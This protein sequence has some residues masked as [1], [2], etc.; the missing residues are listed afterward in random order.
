MLSDSENLYNI[1][2]ILNNFILN[3][4]KI[5]SREEIDRILSQLLFNGII[6]SFVAPD[7][8]GSASEQ[9]LLGPAENQREINN[10]NNYYGDDEDDNSQEQQFNH[11]ILSNKINKKIIAYHDIEGPILFYDN[12]STEPIM[13]S[14]TCKPSYA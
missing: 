5:F 11:I 10:L 13:A 14:H 3:L 9:A 4:K 8:S 6:R 1:Y 7:S 12:Y 2:N